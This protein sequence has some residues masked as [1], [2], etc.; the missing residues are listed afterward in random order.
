MCGGL[1]VEQV[2]DVAQLEAVAGAAF[3]LDHAAFAIDRGGVEL[4]LARHFAHQEQ[5]GVDPRLVGGGEVELVGGAVEAGRGIG[6]GAEG[7]PLPLEDPDHLALGDVGGAVE[8]HM[9]DE[10]G[11]AALIVGLGDRAEREVEADRGGALG[12]GVAADGVAHAVGE[13]AVAD[14]GVGDDVGDGEAPRVGGGGLGRARAEAQAR[15]ASA[16]PEREPV[17]AEKRMTP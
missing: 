8:R 3:A 11:E 7:E 2:G 16:T 5:G 17:A 6:V 13:A 12:R 10:V 9:L 14:R 4:H 15:A 1:E